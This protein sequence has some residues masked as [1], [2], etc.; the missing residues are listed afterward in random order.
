MFAVVALEYI[1]E[2]ATHLWQ[3]PELAQK[4]QQLASQ[5]QHG[6]ETHAVVQ[7]PLHGKIYA[8]EVDGL[9]NALLMDDANVPSLLSIP[10]LG[11]QHYDKE[12]YSNTKRF[13][14]SQDNPTFQ[15]GSNPMTGPIAG[16]GSPHM[17]AAIAQNIW[18]MSLAV[19][20]LSRYAR[21]EYLSF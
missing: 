16:Y 20:G 13:I 4:A 7:H 10:Y 12:I 21:T 19:Q 11:Y 5:I 15:S 6:I 3:N 2:M 8:Y 1:V 14:F 17:K 9:G 18:P